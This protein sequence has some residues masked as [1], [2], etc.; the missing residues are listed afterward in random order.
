MTNESKEMTAVQNGRPQEENAEMNVKST[1]N[2]AKPKAP[3]KA[4]KAA[5][6]A[7]ESEINP[8]LSKPG[9]I[10]FIADSIIAN[11]KR[12]LSKKEILARLVKKF[13]EREEIKMLATINAQVPNRLNREKG[14]NIIK[15]GDKYFQKGSLPKDWK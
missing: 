9:V 13:P 14:L 12:G 11:Q 8:N 5:P 1:K 4:K 2:S 7:K 6:K 15:D 10:R 3:K